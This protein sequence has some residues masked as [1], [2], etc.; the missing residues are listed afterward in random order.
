MVLLYSGRGGM[1]LVRVGNSGTEIRGSSLGLYGCGNVSR[2]MILAAQGFGMDVGAAQW[3][4]GDE[5]S[6]CR[7]T[8]M[9]PSSLPTKSRI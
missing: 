4:L 6:Y 7:S 8:L 9:T 3:G 1:V 2:F 5:S